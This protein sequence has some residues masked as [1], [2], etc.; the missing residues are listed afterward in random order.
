MFLS[1]NARIVAREQKAK[2]ASKGIVFVR[3][4][5]GVNIIEK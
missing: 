3:Q 4:S 5:G 1:K 2:A